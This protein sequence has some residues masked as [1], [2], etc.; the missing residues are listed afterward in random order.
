MGGADHTALVT[1]A[2]IPMLDALASST[3]I[4]K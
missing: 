1:D 4:R 2:G 3:A